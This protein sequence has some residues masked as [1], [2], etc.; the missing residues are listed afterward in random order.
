MYKMN[1][2]KFKQKKNIKKEL[3]EENIEIFKNLIKTRFYP[4]YDKLYI[5]DLKRLS[6]RFNIRLDRQTKLLFCKKCE[7][8]W[9][10]KGVKIRINSKLKTK[11]YIC[12][13]C[14]FRRRFKYK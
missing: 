7:I 8:F 1:S 9:D 5:R 14:G 13:N 4:E 3:A 10:S 2:K 6:Q 11:E 12:Q